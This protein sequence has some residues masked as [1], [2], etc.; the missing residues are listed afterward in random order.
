MQPTTPD[1]RRA[2]RVL[3][4]QPAPAVTRPRA[5]A[6]TRPR[7]TRRQAPPEATLPDDAVAGLALMI[8]AYRTYPA[9]ARV[10]SKVLRDIATDKGHRPTSDVKDLAELVY[11][12]HELQQ[13]RPVYV[14][15]IVRL[16]GN[17]L[18]QADSGGRRAGQ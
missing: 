11:Q 10:A 1:A 8:H 9:S 15:A 12:L 7:R 16:V 4:F 17:A 3:T 13:R 5:L 6:A 14:D 18:A 2:A